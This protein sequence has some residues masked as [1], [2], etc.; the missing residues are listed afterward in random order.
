MADEWIQGWPRMLCEQRWV[1]MLHC[2]AQCVGWAL[3]RTKVR[4]YMH[5]YATGQLRTNHLADGAN[6]RSLRHLSWQ[7]STSLMC[8]HVSSAVSY[9][10]KRV[11]TG[12]LAELR[13]KVGRPT[14]C[15]DRPADLVLVWTAAAEICDRCR[16]AYLSVS[17]L[18]SSTFCFFVF[19]LH[20]FFYKAHRSFGVRINFCHS[21]SN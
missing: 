20:W 3:V 15:I 14:S 12:S 1:S 16:G 17:S 21:F 18:A 9:K 10:F 2:R 7:S 19:F 8:V 11:Q 13:A 6:D 4:P 5:L